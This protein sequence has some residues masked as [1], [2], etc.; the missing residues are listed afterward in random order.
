[1]VYVGK[2]IL[3]L[4]VI[5]KGVVVVVNME[6]ESVVSWKELGVSCACMSVLRS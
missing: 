1:V 2:A 3:V 5:V 4:I 6:E